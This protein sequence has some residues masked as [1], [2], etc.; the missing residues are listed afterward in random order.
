MGKSGPDPRDVRPWGTAASFIVN[1]PVEPPA[2]RAAEIIRDRLPPG[3]LF[4]GT[5]WR[6]SPAPFLLEAK[7]VRE[8]EFLGRVLLQFYR[9]VNLLYRRSVAG[10]QPAWVA[11]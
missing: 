1:P 6:I 8:I 9:V 11:S 5:D 2:Q 10:K 7:L 3:G 4:A